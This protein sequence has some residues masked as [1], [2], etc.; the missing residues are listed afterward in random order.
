MQP[1]RDLARKHHLR[2]VARH[3]GR[4]HIAEHVQID[5]SGRGL[6][7]C[8]HAAPQPAEVAVRI[9]GLDA[10]NR[11]LQ[12]GSVGD[13]LGKHLHL[14]R[15]HNDLRTLRRPP[16]SQHLQS[17]L[18]GIRETR[19][20]AHAERVIDSDHHQAVTGCSGRALQKRLRKRQHQQQHQQGAQRKQQEIAQTPMPHRTLRAALKKHQRTY[21]TR[22]A[23]VPAQ[24]MHIHRQTQRGQ[25]SQKP[26]R[27]QAHHFPP[28]RRR[29]YSPNVASSGLSV[30][31]R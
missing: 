18:L 11:R 26:G 21:R 14:V 28:G 24:Q 6:R 27:E 30:T 8:A 4:L 20:G 16:R 13:R 15:Q 5:Q 23:G 25:T 7:Q 17:L 31:N 22:R 3:V 1:Q 9:A 2:K 29:R 12:R 10:G 19:T